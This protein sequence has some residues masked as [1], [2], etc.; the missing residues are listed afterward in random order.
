MAKEQSIEALLRRSLGKDAA[1][2]LL[3]KID[4]MVARRATPAAIQKAVTA[5]LQRQFVQQVVSAAVS[6]IGPVSPV[7]ARTVQA[8]V[9]PVVRNVIARIPIV[10]ARS[11]GVQ[12]R[13]GRRA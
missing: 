12:A 2:A 8:K 5:D 13:G 1:G 6:G 3:D 4:R 7:Q 11:A 10:I 9:T